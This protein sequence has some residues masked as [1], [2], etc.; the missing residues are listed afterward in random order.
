MRNSALFRVVSYGR[1]HPVLRMLRSRYGGIVKYLRW[2]VG[3][4]L[5]VLGGCPGP[6]ERLRP[7]R[8]ISMPEFTAE[9]LVRAE[10]LHIVAATPTGMVER[11][12]EADEIAVSFDAVM[13]ALEAV[14]DTLDFPL[15]LEP[16]VPGTC[17]WLGT[18]TIVFRPDT[19]LTPATEFKVT[20]PKGVKAVE[21]QMLKQDYS[22]SF[23]T[24]R[25]QLENSDPYHNQK[26]VELDHWVWL[27]FNVPMDPK[28]A[29]RFIRLVEPDGTERG[30]ALRQP[31]SQE[32]SN[33]WWYNP[34]DTA[35]VLVL[36]PKR[37]LRIQ[38]EY[39][40]VLKKGLLA[41]EGNL[42][43]EKER[44]LVFKTFNR[45]RFLGV[46]TEDGHHPE[47][48]LAFEFSNPV[49]I[50]NLA[51]GVRFKPELE[52]PK[53]YH[54]QMWASRS[55]YLSLPLEPETSYQVVLS[56]W[57]K[58]QFGNR[59]GHDVRFSLKTVSYRPSV[60]M[61]T[62]RGIVESEGKLKHPVR[63]VN[64]ESLAVRMRRL[65]RSEVVPFW[66]RAYD[67]SYR[68]DEP[69]ARPYEEPGFYT[70]EKLWRPNL[71]WNQRTLRSI[72]LKHG[73]GTRKSGFLFCE[74]DM[75]FEPY[76]G[77]RHRRALLQVAPYGLT[78]KFSPEN[79]LGYVTRLRNCAPVPGA[80]VQLRDDQ[81]HVAWS[82]RTDKDG[83]VKFPGWD[84]L[85]TKAR[86]EWSS[87]RV[88]MFVDGEWGEAFVHSG[89]GTGSSPYEFGIRYDWHPEP[90]KPRGFL[91]TEKGLYKAGDTVR[92]K[93]MV[94]AKK[95]GRWVIP[96]KRSGTFVVT[97]SRNEE[98]IEKKISLS[99]RGSFDIQVPLAE[100]A[101]S[102][103]YS[104][105][106]ELDDEEF[107]G[108]FRVEAYRPAE[109]EVEVKAD[110]E[111]Y[112][113]GDRFEAT[114]SG[115]YLFGA[116]MA[117]DVVS[118]TVSL[119]P[120]GFSPPGH[121]GFQWR[122]YMDQ[123]ADRH[124]QLASGSGELDSD[125]RISVKAKLDLGKG[126]R[127]CQ[128]SCE[129]TVTAKNERSISGRE[130]YMVHRGELYVG[131]KADDH[132]I[133]LGDS[134][135]FDLIAVKPDGEL[136]S[137][138]TVSVTVFQR[139]WKS[140]RKARTGGRYSWVS[141]KQDK[142]AGGLKVKT[143][144][145]PVRRWFKPQKP[146]RY[147]LKCETRD[148]R[149]NSIRTDVSFWVAGKGEAAWMMRD[150]DMID[151]V[152]DKDSYKPGDT[153]RI[154]VKSPW[155]RVT[156]MV[157]IEREF[158]I[159]HFRTSIDGNA[160]L[161][162]IPIREQ[163]LPNVFVSVILLKG[164]TADNKFGEQG[165]DLGKPGFKIGYVELPVDPESKRL[166][167]KVKT[168]RDEYRPG[169]E[170]ALELDV[171]DHSGNPRQA[172]VVLAVVD[173]GVLKLTG[174]QTP[175]PFSVFY[176]SRP[177]SVAT[178]ESRLHIIGQR[179]YGEK[180][181]N[182][183][184]GGGL[185]G[186][187]EETGKRGETYGFSYREKFLETALWLPKVRTDASGKAKVRFELPDNLTT[188]KVIAVAAA[189]ER[190]GSGDARF[191]ANKPLL[192]QPSF[193]RFV[194]PD[195]EFHAG[196]MV[197]NRTKAEMSVKVRA[198]VEK[199]VELIGDAVQQVTVQPDRP[200]EVLFEYRC[201]GRDS[202]E[203]SFE[204]SAGEE[205]DALKVML[206]VRNP[207]ITEAVAVYEQT[208]DSVAVQWVTAPG[209][210]FARVG[211]LEIT[212]ASSG[213]AGLERGVEY[214][215]TYPYECLEQRLS[216]ILPFIV[217]EDLVNQ[218]KLSTLTGKAL[219]EFVQA[220]LAKV[221]RYQ[222]ESGGFH[223]W[224]NSEYWWKPSP[225]LSAYCMYALARARDAGYAIDETM[226]DRGKAYLS[227]WLG[228]A[229]KGDDWPYSV[230]EYQTTRCLA[231]YALSLWGGPT[232]SYVNTLM[233]RLDQISV[234]GKAYLLKAVHELGMG[235]T[236]EAQIVRALN[237]KVKVG[238]T[239]VHYEEGTK[240]GWIFHSNVR[241][242]AIVLQALLET[243]GEIE[244][245]E[246]VVKWLVSERKA[247]RWRTTQ[248]NIY[249][250]DALATFY[251]VYEKVRPDFT[252]V[253]KL[254]G[255]AM[256]NEVFSGRKL[257][258]RRKFIPMDE[259][260]KDE[261]QEVRIAKKGQGRLYY[262]LRLSYAP[263]GELKPKDE[264][265]RIE[266]TI[267]PV[268]GRG[269]GF[270]RGRQYLVTLKVYTSQE[271]LYVVLDDPVPAGF[272]IVNTSFATE[273]RQA[274]QTLS[275]AR[276]SDVRQG[277]WGS[278]NH[279]EIYDDRYVL[280][281]TSLRKGFHSRTYLVKALTPGK[282]FMP[283][284]KVEEMYMPEVF[285]YTGQK[286]VEV[287]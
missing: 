19:F 45:F 267:T 87:P 163:Y 5:L 266:K 153:A 43:L 80:R 20:V 126:L 34:M 265:F 162:R 78:A 73:L 47:D 277:W 22:F 95:M 12:Q 112:I 29:R 56:R 116:V 71:K 39:E 79:G 28:R 59:L 171:S 226:T 275:Q 26:M 68:Y 142:K 178:A 103:Y 237:N 201:I 69:E 52:I 124:R 125:G 161:I 149:R 117:G 105:R 192:V 283:A 180:G 200:V 62:G 196:V 94:R 106:Y 285:G 250:F 46:R 270:V 40:M 61:P 202:A 230:N 177:L 182:A 115:R 197:H 92:I 204:A 188:W 38:T 122:P 3:F 224:T 13:T 167:V 287:K 221:P 184:G 57:L 166:D 139:V 25:P 279:E 102:G 256:L 176:S 51:T 164:R 50:S 276:K 136:V 85:G 234:F 135:G 131:V 205:Q 104:M 58:D 93:G 281:A 110:K 260:V 121:D 255:K 240:G 11:F 216:K 169:G 32:K 143:G 218:F 284:T 84:E 251:R 207:R 190:F 133:E 236:L 244:F 15:L 155:T 114:V 36:I 286:W 232:G 227:N 262:G 35:R 63:L 175:D 249:V 75:L 222:D 101:V 44:R 10:P 271:R 160:D 252:V 181:E 89:W 264:G 151:L 238:P 134:L 168:S 146:G 138:Q 17:H 88:W 156:A 269:T 23:S 241:T 235:P 274:W 195:D 113:A 187:G 55:P 247:G 119:S 219:R 152:R 191:K 220:E 98:V 239:T 157:T 90:K 282:F 91:F 210:A 231:V 212:V 208:Q 141:E 172:E 183:G 67:Y 31:R 225:Y 107:R 30:F 42:G 120:T 179:N 144:K 174:F 203:F 4:V 18:R 127:T 109:F 99:D 268:K 7:T 53:R 129:G 14:P 280:F 170:V 49:P 233:E 48:A 111:E 66:R 243:R 246:K 72:D 100:D 1:N 228:Y 273:S 37:G 145:E 33:R 253:M 242:T 86:N 214:L 137:G 70:Y 154:L 213:L 54:D 74:L 147:W 82:G 199:G 259:L 60:Q 159:D 173:L 185:D 27:E 21:G 41:R 258:T 254:E 16:D 165:E 257:D 128:V 130:T 2:A 118:W 245:A 77:S 229:S 83:F 64:I 76:H 223:F 209:D 278:F 96:G 24:V 108:S 6:K 263:K 186:S 198:R 194:R 193:P 81:N 132:F 217:G 97:D 261:R 9:E 65:D 140:A 206:V 215:R 272:E 8:K 211:G 248:E 148:S 123:G 150:D 158:V 189:G